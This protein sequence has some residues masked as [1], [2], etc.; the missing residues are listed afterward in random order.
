MPL[1][2]VV[3]KNI[4]ALMERAA[5]RG[6]KSL[7]SQNGLAKKAGVGQRTVGR[8]V[9]GTQE[10]GVDVV[11]AIAH[12]Y[13]LSGWQLLVEDFDP[14]NPPIL[15]IASEAERKFWQS[16]EETQQRMRDL[17]REKLRAEGKAQRPRGIPRDDRDRPRPASGPRERAHNDDEAE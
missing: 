16:F 4:R 5:A 11:A 1:K 7:A 10:P 2:R 6:E 3:A 15:R 8:I 14:N 13:G 17:E 9:E 12:A